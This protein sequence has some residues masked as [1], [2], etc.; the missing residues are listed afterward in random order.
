M[1]RKLINTTDD[2]AITILRLVLGVVFLRARAQ[3]PSLVWRLWILRHHGFFTKSAH[4]RPR[5]HFLAICAE[6]L[7]GIG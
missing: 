5:S 2:L 3:R 6:F 7:G 4:P 1:F